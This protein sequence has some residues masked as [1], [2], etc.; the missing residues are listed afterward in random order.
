LSDLLDYENAQIAHLNEK[1][2]NGLVKETKE[3][4]SKMRLLTVSLI[5]ISSAEEETKQYIGTINSR[6]SGCV[7][8]R[9]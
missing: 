7:Y 2:L 3:E 9:S 4:N 1:A 8:A 5:V 6:C